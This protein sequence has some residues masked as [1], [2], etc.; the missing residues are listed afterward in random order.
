MDPLSMLIYA[1]PTSSAA[2]GC[3]RRIQEFLSK[4][5]WKDTRYLEAS[6]NISG[7]HDGAPGEEAVELTTIRDKN[8]HDRIIVKDASFGW[9]PD[10][11]IVKDFSLRVTQDTKLTVILGPVGC[12][13]STL[14]KG[15]LGESLRLG[16]TVST[17]TAE[18]SFCD[19]NPWLFNGSVRDNI[20]GESEFD[21]RFYDSVVRACALDIDFGQ[22][23]HGDSTAVGSKGVSLSGGQKQRIV[24]ASLGS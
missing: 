13:K 15:L 20:I 16:G 9:Q 23:P 21:Q 6:E 19:H 24:S 18:I 1:I 4:E 2:M 3:F 14:L 10:T 7:L 17:A 12:G 22:F 5:S 11:R 8:N